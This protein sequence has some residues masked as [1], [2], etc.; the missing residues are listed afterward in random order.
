[1]KRGL[2]RPA[3]A[4]FPLVLMSVSLL[5]GAENVAWL[6][7]VFYLIQI[8]SL[9]AADCF[10][11]AA[12]REPGVRRV[13]KRFG[14]A[15]AQLLM[16]AALAG[17]AW[18]ALEMD[19]KAGWSVFAVGML[20]HIEQLFEE[21][22]YA[23]CRN[24]DGVVLSV[25]SNLLLL[26]GILMDVSGGVDRLL[27]LANF[28]TLF[29]A[30]LGMVISVVTCY[31]IEPMRAFSLLPRNLA[32]FPKAAIQTLLYPA[33]MAL[34]AYLS[35]WWYESVLDH[36]LE[37]A[38]SVEFLSGLLLWRLARTVCRRS[39]D[40]SRAL[41]LLLVSVVSAL[42]IASVW[43]PELIGY[44]CIAWI[45]LFC[46]TIVFCAPSWRLYAG[47]GLLWIALGFMEP[48][49]DRIHMLICL[50]CA[51]VAFVLNLHRAFL[52]KV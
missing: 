41:N 20:I 23:L 14:G 24:A 5:G 13:D 8:L 27:D 46:T 50:G 36:M 47:V 49:M 45:V 32:F 9:C 28:Y 43:I 42:M 11:N 15:L 26:G 30:G 40:E 39:S 19:T 2:M 4:L 21:R 51:I 34:V 1:M 3:T 18:H 31:A 29:G 10:R 48:H 17:L 35:T 16:G 33:V 12:A 6:L 7:C 52:R 37:L 44:E 22:M 38:G 25:I